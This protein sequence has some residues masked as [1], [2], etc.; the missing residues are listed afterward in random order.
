MTDFEQEMSNITID[1]LM[2]RIDQLK[3]ELASTKDALDEAYLDIDLLVLEKDAVAARLQ[4][5]LEEG[6]NLR[7]DRDELKSHINRLEEMFQKVCRENEE[8]RQRILK[9]LD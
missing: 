7:M 5:A 6:A 1:I 4:K 8:R 3:E 2:K 9:E